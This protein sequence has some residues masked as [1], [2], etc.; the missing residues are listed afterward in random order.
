MNIYEKALSVMKEL[1]E[2]DCQF[3]LA[4]AKENI[5]S[6]RVVDTYFKDE[7]FYVVTYSN[8]QKCKEI[9]SNSNVSLC[10]N[11]YRFN[12]NAYNIGHPLKEE[13]KELREILIKVFEPWYFAHNNEE[14]EHMCYVKIELKDGFFYK[15]GTGYKVNFKLKEAKEFPFNLDEEPVL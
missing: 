6:V 10:N 9:A 7:A 13:N 1:F 15:D 2:K 5:P 3:S 4:T 12:G 11:F 8:S 14:H